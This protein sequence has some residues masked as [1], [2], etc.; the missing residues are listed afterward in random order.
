MLID[1]LREDRLTY[2]KSGSKLESDLLG[3]VIG[4]AEQSDKQIADAALIKIIVSVLKSVQERIDKR[5][6]YSD[7]ANAVKEKAC[8][9]QYLPAVIA[10]TDMN[11]MFNHMAF[12]NKGEFMT[13]AK[14]YAVVNNMLFDGKIAAAYYDERQAARD[15]SF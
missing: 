12:N 5:Y 9:D 11:R 3:V 7:H 2:R 10:N 1:K 8:L 14:Q 15:Q 13:V 6:S 4:Q